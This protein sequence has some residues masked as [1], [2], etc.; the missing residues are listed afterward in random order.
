MSLAAGLLP[1]VQPDF[2]EHFPNDFQVIFGSSITST[3]IVVFTLNLV[4]NHW[5]RRPKGRVCG[6]GR[7]A[8][9]RGRSKRPGRR[10]ER[11][12]R[13][14]SDATGGTAG[15]LTDG[16]PAA[17]VVGAFGGDGGGH[18]DG[19]ELERGHDARRGVVGHPGLRTGGGDGQGR[20]RVGHGHREAAHADLLLALI[21]GVT[22]LA[23]HLEV[24]DQQVRVG[25]G[26]GSVGRHAAPL[27]QSPRLARRKL[28]QQGLADRRAVRADAAARLGE[29]PHRVSAWHL[30][31]VDDL[32][33]VE[34]GQVGGLPR[35]EDQLSQ[36][37]PQP[38]TE[39]AAGG[40]AQPDQPRAECVPAR[41]LL[42]DVAPVDQRA[43]QPVN[44][45]QREP[46]VGRELGQAQRAARVGQHLEQVEGPLDGLHSACG[47]AAAGLVAARSVAAGRR[48]PDALSRIVHASMIQN[49]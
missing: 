2:Y 49:S 1:A 21:E 37:R 14:L 13:D 36:E 33:A 27:Q 29:H 5:T 40:L 48:Q 22:L 17:R 16:G 28:R 24:G 9:G 3:V 12:G 39:H 25:D 30:S 15:A 23:D 35:L 34:H 44:G 20:G 26:R 43:H 45:G 10:R 4:F 32:I 8:R 41:G 31:D 19:G 7:G 11:R 46:G 42:T 38:G 6:V 18:L 47:W